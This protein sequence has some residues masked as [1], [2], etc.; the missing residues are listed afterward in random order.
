[1]LKG[2]IK[3]IGIT[4]AAGSGKSVL[5]KALQGQFGYYPM[6]FSAGLKK[7]IYTLPHLSEEKFA[8]REWKEKVH[9]FYGKSPREMMQTL[10]TEWAR[11]LIHPD[12]WVWVA[13]QKVENKFTVT[14]NICNYIFDDVRFENEAEWIRNTGGLIVVLRRDETPEVREHSSEAGINTN[15][16]DYVVR[17]NRSIEDLCSSAPF[18][19]DLAETARSEAV[20]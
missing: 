5:S 18:L 13:A 6:S 14:R 17:N 9:P 7:M 2:N 11:N 3:L 4:G 20:A 15:I 8:D 10:G 19:N 16:M 1:M 12:I